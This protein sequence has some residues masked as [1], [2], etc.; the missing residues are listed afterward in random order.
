MV[1]RTRGSSARESVVL[2][3][4]IV[5]PRS[6]RMIESVQRDCG[7]IM[8]GPIDTL[9]ERAAEGK[10]DGDCV[11]VEIYSSLREPPARV[12]V[13]VGVHDEHCRTAP[14]DEVA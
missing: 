3:S 11:G 5:P 1:A 13:P 2:P 6:A 12:V 10:H 4:E 9:P 14:A 7:N 8:D